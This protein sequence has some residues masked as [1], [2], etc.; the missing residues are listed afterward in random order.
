M[1]YSVMMYTF[2]K[3]YANSYSHFCLFA[4]FWA[5]P[6]ISF[7]AGALLLYRGMT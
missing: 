2:P 7:K 1:I 6:T 4:R 3:A 5:Q